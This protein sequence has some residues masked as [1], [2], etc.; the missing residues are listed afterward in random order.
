[1]MNANILKELDEPQDQRHNMEI[2]TPNFFERNQT[3]WF[4]D[5]VELLLSL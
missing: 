4:G 1:M 2:V 3:T 5:N